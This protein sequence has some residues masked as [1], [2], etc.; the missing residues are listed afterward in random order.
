MNMMHRNRLRLM[1]LFTA[2]FICIVFF[3]YRILDLA[4]DYDDS[5]NN[6][7]VS[8]REIKTSVEPN[9]GVGSKLEHTVSQVGE[10]S[11]GVEVSMVFYKCLEDD[12]GSLLNLVLKVAVFF[13]IHLFFM[14]LFFLCVK[15]WL[16]KTN[17]I[18]EHYTPIIV[19]THKKDGKKKCYPSYA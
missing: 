4:M 19:Y 2:V 17:S 18:S 15:R 6:A 13:M 11:F 12:K 5:Y 14:Q 8:R 9:S 1:M 10:R 7:S 3:S 16:I